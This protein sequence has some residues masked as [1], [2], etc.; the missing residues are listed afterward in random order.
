MRQAEAQLAL[1]QAGARTETIRA[2][3]AAVVQAQ[4]ALMQRQV[5]LDDTTLRAPF[6]GTIAAL[7]LEVGEQVAAGVAV[8]QLADQTVWHIETD[9]LTEINV[10][11]VQEGDRVA[12][13]VDALPDLELEGTVIRIK[14]L[15][16]NK[17]GDITYTATIAPDDGDA[18]LRWNMTAS[19]TIQ[20]AEQTA[21]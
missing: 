1:L 7:D 4:T 18:R 8:V 13:S 2:A 19:V 16:E 10:V 21:Q 14:P 6:A 11:Y 5:E 9:D 12:I 3:E 20:T 15:G 17:Q